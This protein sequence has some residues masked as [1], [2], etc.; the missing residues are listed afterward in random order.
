M[1][2]RL[3]RLSIEKSE[4]GGE[5]RRRGE[6]VEFFSSLARIPH[7]PAGS[8]VLRR[9]H[10][11]LDISSLPVHLPTHQYFC[12]CRFSSRFCLKRVATICDVVLS[13]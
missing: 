9:H 10:Q 6:E 7:R 11:A 1:R 8:L 12:S 3:L 13:A 4:G 5:E 2:L